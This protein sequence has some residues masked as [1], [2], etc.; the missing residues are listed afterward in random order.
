MQR[1]WTITDSMQSK[2]S[3]LRADKNEND[4]FFVS[5]RHAHFVFDVCQAQSFATT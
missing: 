1:S 4:I 3:E 5:R 2:I